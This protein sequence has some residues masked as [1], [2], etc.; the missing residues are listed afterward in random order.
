ME[1]K[2]AY[3]IRHYQLG[4]V[5]YCEGRTHCPYRRGNVA[6]KCWTAGNWK[7]RM[8]EQDLGQ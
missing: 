2:T 8:N 4:Y 7:A 1:L 5:A 6:W 3:Q